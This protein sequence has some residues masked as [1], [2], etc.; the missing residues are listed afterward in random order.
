MKASIKLILI[1]FTML[2][3]IN[4][5]AQKSYHTD[6]IDVLNYNIELEITDFTNQ[7]I[8]GHTEVELTPKYNNLH[9]VQLDL[10]S[11]FIDSITINGVEQNFWD[12]NDTLLTIPLLQPANISDTLSVTV[13]YYGHPQ[14]DPGANH[15][16]GFKWSGNAAYN[17]GVGFVA[18][19]HNFGRCWFPCNDN[20]VDRATFDFR[21]LVSD[22]LSH[23]AVC[24]GTLLEIDSNYISSGKRLYH[25][26]ISNKIPTYLASVAV[27]QYTLVPDTFAGILGQIPIQLW[28]RTADTLKAKNTFVN[29]KSILSLF[30]SKFGPYR[31][32]RVGYVG[33]DFDAGAMEHATNIAFPNLCITGTTAYEEIYAHELSHHWFGDLITC[34]SAQEM[35]LNEGWATFC[36]M[37]YEEAF[38]GTST[39]ITNKRTKLNKVLRYNQIE[40]GGFVTLNQVPDSITYGS[41]AYDK[42]GLVVQTLRSYLGDSLFYACVKDMLETFK[43]KDISSEQMRDY[44]SSR[45]GVDMNGFFNS[46]VFTPGF[47]HFSVDS[48]KV[49]SNLPNYDVTVYAR[50]KMRGRSTYSNNNRLEITFMDSLWNKTSRIIEISGGSGS[51]T[52]TIPF[53]PLCAFMDL[54][55]KTDDAT[56][57]TYKTIK[58]TG[59]VTFDQTYFSGN[60]TSV[61]DSAFIRVEHN[62]VAPDDFKTHIPGVLIS[63]ER[64]WKIDGILPSSFVMTGKFYYNKTTS[65]T[66][67]YLDNQLITNVADSIVLLYR[68]GTWDDWKIIPHT[69]LGN[70]YNGYIKID[71]V[72]KGEYALG[73][74]N[75]QIYD[76]TGMLY[77]NSDNE[78]RIIPNPANQSCTVKYAHK[79]GD[80]LNLINSNGHVVKTINIINYNDEVNLSLSNLNSGLYFIQINRKNGKSLTS[81]IVVE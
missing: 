46:W 35:W 81:R 41:T 18:I 71:S 20:F 66:N 38:M 52:F 60:V 75:W 6:S 29:L 36:E 15:W 57:D 63:R 22:S 3:V 23:V 10:L 5:K 40:E 24:N 55:E 70:N 76:S 58:N 73:I 37:V 62:W 68:K 33:V 74:R 25:W 27:A 65:S 77:I 1:A 13:Y 19:P 48:F 51:A 56:S 16:G 31:W 80:Q 45:S 14:E 7:L 79:N 78:I 8:S 64:Y 43:F 53:N 67:G 44:L 12:Y 21:I 28:V 69:L 42:G 50:E 72:K 59:S 26:R 2:I 49:V 32:E 61:P 11:F 47:P 54:Y 9:N 4:V 30:E 17:L 39:F 34:H